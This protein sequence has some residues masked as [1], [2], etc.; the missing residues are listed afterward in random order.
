MGVIRMRVGK[1]LLSMKNSL[2]GEGGCRVFVIRMRLFYN[3]FLKVI[4][5]Y[6]TSI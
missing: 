2:P 5:T 6:I 1:G 3:H 4:K